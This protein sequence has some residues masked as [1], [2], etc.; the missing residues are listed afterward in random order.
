MH[1]LPQKEVP[2]IRSLAFVAIL[3]AAVVGATATATAQNAP[4]VTATGIKIGQ[5]MPYSGPVSAFGTLGKGEIAYF[6]MI[7]DQGG[8]NAVSYT[9]LRAHETRHDLVC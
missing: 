1:R 9:H 8:V 5:T 6:N 3:L 4:G 7:N 2:M